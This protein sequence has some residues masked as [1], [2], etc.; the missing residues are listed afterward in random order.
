MFLTRRV[1]QKQSQLSNPEKQ[2]GGQRECY[3]ETG[4]EMFTARHDYLIRVNQVEI[5]FDTRLIVSPLTLSG[6]SLSRCQ[7]G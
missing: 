6:V 7:C 3:E 1:S 5:T 4:Q 2:C